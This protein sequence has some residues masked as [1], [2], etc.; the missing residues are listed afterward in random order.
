MSECRCNWVV[1]YAMHVATVL[2]T[3][4]SLSLSLLDTHTHTL[5]LSLSWYPYPSPSL[6]S[7]LTQPFTFSPMEPIRI[8]TIYLFFLSKRTKLKKGT[9]VNWTK[10]KD[11][12][13]SVF[14]KVEI[15]FFIYIIN[16]YR[17]TNFYVYNNKFKQY[18]QARL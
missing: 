15:L 9:F 16:K 14:F 4:I 10:S 17:K 11:I 8:T 5:S 12:F 18:S 6:F 7:V 13:N 3:T 1:T 2:W